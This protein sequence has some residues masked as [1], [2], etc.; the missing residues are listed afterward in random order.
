[1]KEKDEKYYEF[2]KMRR[3][4]IVVI[5]SGYMVLYIFVLAFFLYSNLI[6]HIK[7]PLELNAMMVC[8]ISCLL[9]YIRKFYKHLI[10]GEVT[11]IRED[12]VTSDELGCIFY[13]VA[14]PLTSLAFGLITFYIIEVFIRSTITSSE[15]YSVTYKMFVYLIEFFCGFS[16]G[17]FVE[18]TIKLGERT[19]DKLTKKAGENCE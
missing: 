8:F 5:F 19:I 10:R 15:T 11:I 16:I 13:F 14:R 12:E 4:V 18:K 7:V 1:M 2:L 9:Y 17:R 6:L 3:G